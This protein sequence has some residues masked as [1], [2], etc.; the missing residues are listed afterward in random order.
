MNG[1][2]RRLLLRAVLAWAVASASWAQTAP[3]VAY[4][5]R[6]TNDPLSIH[7]GIVRPEQVRIVAELAGEGRLGREP[8]SRL[9]QRRRAWLGVNGG[10]FRIGEPDDG[11]PAGVLKVHGTWVSDAPIPRGALGWTAD[12]RRVLIGRLATRWELDLD[13]TKWAIAGLNR[14]RREGEVVLFS[15]HYGTSTRTSSG[16]ELVVKEGRVAEVHRGGDTG[17]P[18][19]GWVVSF[20]GATAGGPFEVGVGARLCTTIGGPD[21]HLD[22]QA[23]EFVVG[24]TPV[25]VRDGRPVADF[26]EEG[27]RRD[28]VRERHP[29]TAVGV[30]PDGAWVFVVVDGRRPE[31]S[32]GMTLSELAELMVSLGCREALNLD[33]GGSSTFFLYGQVANRPSDLSGERPVSDAILVLPPGK[34]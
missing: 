14:S 27:V 29:R 1:R 8:V 32:V 9:A 17:I 16:L 31:F 18:P 12:G 11:D 22:W 23:M 15:S 3:A 34:P 26:L 2:F 13:G 4:E 5:H 25:L 33:G 10:F 21:S 24:G 7:I 28:F 6:Q 19:D 30:R 20:G